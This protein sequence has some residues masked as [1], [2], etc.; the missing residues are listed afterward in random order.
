MKY[1][2]IGAGGAGGCLASFMTEG[3]LDVAVVDRGEHLEAI[4]ARGITLETDF[5]G[6]YTVSPVRAFAED[7]YDEQPDVILLCVKEFSVRSVL[8]FIRRVS[9]PGTILIPVISV[10]DI[11]LRLQRE[12]QELDVMDGCIYVAAVIT[13]P[14]TIK[15]YGRILSVVFGVRDQ[16]MYSP[17]LEKIAYDLRM[18]GI[19][20]VV[21]DNIKQE[22]IKKYSYISPLASAMFYYDCTAEELQHEGEARTLF[23]DLMKEVE[24]MA[25]AMNIQ[26]HCDLVG[27]NLSIL[28]GLNKATTVE[29]T[30][31][32]AAGRPSEVDGLVFE[33]LRR[34]DDLNLKAP[35][36]EKVADKAIACGCIPRRQTRD[37]TL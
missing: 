21:S 16:D 31:D 15:M 24:Q 32:I 37:R 9:R 17:W 25:E 20:G 12:L 34:S 3:G 29:M 28:S 27:L 36:Y 2:I 13:A 18:C 8:P 22:M 30:R 1:L 5:R 26:V 33:I 11:G 14:G 35:N 7:E 19:E 10:F 4:K 23:V 6:T